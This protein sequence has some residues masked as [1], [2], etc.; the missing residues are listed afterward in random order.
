MKTFKYFVFVLS[1]ALAFPL[2][3]NAAESDVIDGLKAVRV[4]QDVID[5]FVEAGL[6][7][8]QLRTDL[9]VKLRVVGIE[10]AKRGGEP[11]LALIIDGF[12]LRNGLY[13]YAISLS[14]DEYVTVKR[15]S[16]SI[17]ATTW[18]THPIYGSTS[19]VFDIRNAAKRIMD[20]FINEWLE[21]NPSR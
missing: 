4:R 11:W 8:Q 19:N 18:S 13:V 17:L 7:E 16:N 15:N 10:V 20:E 5:E 12:K 1:M 3:C 9:E 21:E 6:N 14:L 2:S